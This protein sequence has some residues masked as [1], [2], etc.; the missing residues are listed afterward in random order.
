MDT[1]ANLASTAQRTEIVLNQKAGLKF[2]SLE[3]VEGQS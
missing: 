2:K 1:S 3:V